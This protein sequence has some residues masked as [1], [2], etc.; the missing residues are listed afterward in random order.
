[1]NATWNSG[2]SGKIH[3]PFVAHILPPLATRISGETTSVEKLEGLKIIRF[4]STSDC[5]D[6]LGRRLV[7]RVVQ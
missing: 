3:R 4:S 7:V 5:Q 1:L 6:L 2:I